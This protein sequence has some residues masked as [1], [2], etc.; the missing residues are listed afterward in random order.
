MGMT[1]AE[2]ILAKASGKKQV[3][4]G[5]IVEAEIDVAMINDI[6]APLTVDALQK[7]GVEKIWNPKRVVVVLDHQA[8]ATSIDAARD[9]AELRKFVAEQRVP[10][11]YD[12]NEGICHEVLPERGFALPGRLIVGA[13]SHTCTYGALGCF[14]TGIGSTDMAAVLATGKLWFRVP[15]SMKISVE[16]KLKQ[17]V[18]PKD[19]ILRIIGDVGADGATYRS[20]EFVGKGMR[21]ISV[22]GRM[23]MCNMGVEMGAKAAIV[24]SDE[25]T[26]RW[27]VGRTRESYK[28]VDSDKDSTYVEELSYDAAK[29]EPQVACPH[30]VD[31]VSAV[32]EVEGVEVDQAFL[33]SCTNGRLEDLIEAAK[34]LK[35]KRVSKHVR[36]LVVPASREVYL[37]ALGRGL[38][39]LFVEA[40]ARVESPSCA[41]CM[42][43]HIGILAPGEVCISSSNRNFRGRQ[44]SPEAEVYLASPATVVAS[45]LK[46]KII[47]P[48]DV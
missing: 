13:D 41:A 32:R 16:G 40:G 29:L 43:G 17:R 20:V 10:N 7:I 18:A 28:P 9:H 39:K 31:N 4:P 46:G 21:D 45:A 47:D 6:T 14:A 27:L 48:R 38:L 1:I 35:G 34:I 44:G 2:K 24:P 37:D 3:A 11:F 23:T 12:V 30:S 33:G 19:L 36:M 15:E 25:L 42:G 8:P 5:E 22:A 26:K